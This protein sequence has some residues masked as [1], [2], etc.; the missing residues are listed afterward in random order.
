[1]IAADQLTVA[2]EAERER[3]TAMRAEI[4]ERDH[5]P[6]GTAEEH[7]GLAADGTP[8]RAIGKL[9]GCRR[10]IPRVEGPG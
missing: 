7:H 6:F 1:M 3:R 9:V 5:L 10:D 2:H 4:L 8:E